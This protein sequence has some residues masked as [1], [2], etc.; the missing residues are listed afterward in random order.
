M[1]LLQGAAGRS[2]SSPSQDDDTGEKGRSSPKG[3]AVFTTK[4]RGGI[5]GWDF[6]R[7]HIEPWGLNWLMVN[8]KILKMP[9]GAMAVHQRHMGS[10]AVVGQSSPRFT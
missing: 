8:K 5:T 6:R 9:L 3:P 1:A 2:S 7:A 4:A 10:D